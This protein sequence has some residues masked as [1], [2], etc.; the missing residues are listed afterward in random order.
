MELI[1]QSGEVARQSCFSGIR[2][3][4]ATSKTN[5]GTKQHMLQETIEIRTS[6]LELGGKKTYLSDTQNSWSSRLKI[7]SRAEM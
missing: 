6:V 5:L 1:T 7:L 3:A 2:R 4:G